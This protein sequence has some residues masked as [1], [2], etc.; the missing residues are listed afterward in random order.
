L[1]L[2][3]KTTG[4]IK[5]VIKLRGITLNYENASRLQY[6]TFKKMV[7]NFGKEDN[8]VEC[9]FNKLGPDQNS[10]VMTKNLTKKYMVVNRKGLIS[11]DYRLYP[12]GFK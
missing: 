4:E 5:Y 10:R 11:S 8:V 7:L 9:A 3:H 1:K 6:E 12:F 2:A